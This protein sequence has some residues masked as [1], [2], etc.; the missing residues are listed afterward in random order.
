MQTVW[1][2]EVCCIQTQKDKEMTKPNKTPRQL[3]EEHW[4]WLQSILGK[5]REMEKKLFIDSF[6]HGVEHGIRTRISKK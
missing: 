6:I 4:D 3:A 2:Y 5:Q 1:S